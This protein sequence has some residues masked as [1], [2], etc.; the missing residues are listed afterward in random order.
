MSMDFVISPI[1]SG[2]KCT[3][4]GKCAD[5]CPKE[6]LKI[7]GKKVIVDNDDCMQCTHCYAVCKFDAISFDEALKKLSF[8]SFKYANRPAGKN[9][10]RPDDLV[11][12]VQSRRSVR[13]YKVKDVPD[14]I[15]ADLV[16]FAVSAPSGS[17]RQLWEFTVVNGREKVANIA[18]GFGA[19][20]RVLNDYVKNPVKRYLSVLFMGK[21]LLRYYERNYDTV[22][23]SLAEARR[24]RDLLFYG[25][26][27]LIIIHGVMEGST[28]IEDAQYAAYNITLLAHA[29]GL[30][31]C[32][33]GYAQQTLDRIPSL[34]ERLRIPKNNRVLAVLTVGYPDTVFIKPA[35]RK[36]YHAEWL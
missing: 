1:I 9:K 16:E 34:K 14:N 30:G 21:K 13:R 10:I 12:L 4:C 24:G 18:G 20:F 2:K 28:P 11:N 5:I 6:V 8:K 35:L 7:S 17:N 29:M 15:L 23:R 25:A 19:F 22:E 3:L 26:P 32:F 33:I 27:A 36:M 31:T